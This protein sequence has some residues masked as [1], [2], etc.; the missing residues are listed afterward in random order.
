F[1]A[2]VFL[3]L[4]LL[5]RLESS[6]PV[7]FRQ[8]RRGLNGRPF[9]ILKFRSMRVMENGSDVRQAQRHDDRVTRIGFVMRTTS[10][11]EL[12]QLF[13]VLKGEMSLVGPRP[14]AMA[15]DDHYEGLIEGYS[16]RQSVKPGLTGW[17]QVNGFRGET[18][19]LDLM[20]LR[21]QHDLWYVRNR[22]FWLDLRILFRTVGELFRN[23]NV[24]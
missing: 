21:V 3:L 13:N 19:E 18:P 12:P 2:P 1:L 5:I 17:A 4:A 11:D 10:L 15:H 14:H 7:I 6:G 9:K 24:Y 20:V 23:R 22:S 8:H 16:L